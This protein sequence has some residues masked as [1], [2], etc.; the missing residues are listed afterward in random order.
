MI[1]I[2]KVEEIFL[3]QLKKIRIFEYPKPT[4][5]DINDFCQSIILNEIKPGKQNEFIEDYDIVNNY[6]YTD[7][8]RT[9][10]PFIFS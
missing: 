3:I 7:S 9:Q 10:R 5:Q 2:L 8:G 1:Q 6:I 4:F